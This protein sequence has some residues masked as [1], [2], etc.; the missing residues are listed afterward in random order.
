MICTRAPVD[1]SKLFDVVSNFRDSKTFGNSGDSITSK[2]PMRNFQKLPFPNSEKSKSPGI[3]KVHNTLRIPRFQDPS[4]ILQ[5]YPLTPLALFA[6][7][8]PGIP[9]HLFSIE[10]STK[11]TPRGI[12]RSPKNIV[13]N[14]L[15]KTPCNFHGNLTKN[16]ARILPKLF[17]ESIQKKKVKN[18]PVKRSGKRWRNVLQKSSQYLWGK[19]SLKSWRK[20]VLN[21]WKKV[22]RKRSTLNATSICE[23]FLLNNDL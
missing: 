12:P 14:I 9:S 4:T 15:W 6:S 18:S 1:P 10:N 20:R 17:P 13:T 7:Q 19:R 2:T 23:T 22:L 21:I 8:F 16:I 5:K 3:P 11:N